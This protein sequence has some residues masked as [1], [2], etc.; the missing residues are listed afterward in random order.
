[1]FSVARTHLSNLI[2]PVMRAWETN[3]PFPGGGE[4][5]N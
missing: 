3:I 5:E 2:E 4:K 1:M